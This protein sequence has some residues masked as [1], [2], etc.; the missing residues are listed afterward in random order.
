MSR[1]DEHCKCGRLQVT[2][3]CR[4]CWGGTRR[5]KFYLT[6]LYYEVK[7]VTLY[8]S[9]KRVLRIRSYTWCFENKFKMFRPNSNTMTSI[10]RHCS[11]ES[12]DVLSV[13]RPQGKTQVQ[14]QITSC[15]PSCWL[16][17]IRW[18]TTTAKGRKH[19]EYYKIHSH[20]RPQ[21]NWLNNKSSYL[22]Y[23]TEIIVPN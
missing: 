14:I 11:Q 17:V 8:L 9:I 6:A 4:N 19:R 1:I 3:L 16:F 7:I 10:L 20:Q 22:S 12:P 23:A 15:C 18:L 21:T 5:C 2:V 13:V